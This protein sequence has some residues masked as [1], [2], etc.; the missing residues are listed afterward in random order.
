VHGIQS[1]LSLDCGKLQFSDWLLAKVKDDPRMLN[2]TFYSDEQRFRL[3]G[4][5]NSQNTRMWLTEDR[6]STP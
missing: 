1:L 5:L 6:L 4:Y 2:L 3:T